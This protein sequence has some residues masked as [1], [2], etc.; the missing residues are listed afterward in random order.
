MNQD[1]ELTRIMYET[2]NNGFF[3]MS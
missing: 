1:T 2:D 3:N